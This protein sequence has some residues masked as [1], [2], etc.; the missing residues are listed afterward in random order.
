MRGKYLRFGAICVLLTSALGAYVAVGLHLFTSYS[1][2]YAGYEGTCNSLIHW[3]PPRVV[4][5]AFYA[6]GP[7]LGTLSYRSAVPATLAISLAIP[8]LTLTQTVEVHATPAAQTLTFKPPLAGTQ[9][10][11]ALVSPRQRAG[12]LTLQVTRGGSVVCNTSASVVL[13][14]RQWMH[15]ADPVAGDN[16]GYLAG[17]VTPQDP[18]ITALVG[19][20]TTRLEANPD[21]YPALDLLAG[22][23]AGR[24]TPEMVREEVDLLFDTLQFDYHLHY[25]QDNIPVLQNAD[26]IVQL[27]R[28]I[29]SSDDPTGM[30]VETTAILASAVERLGM[31]PFFVLVPGH[32][33]LGVA[34]GPSS[35]ATLAY[36]ETSDL[37][38][39]VTGNQANI[40]GNTEYAT[41]LTHGTIEHIVDIAAER[42][43]GI[44][45]IE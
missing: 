24:A 30:C 7:A 3:N 38:G 25:A 41:N 39:G 35:S 2:A 26:Q 27:P 5:T 17:W 33:F 14:S 44:Q 18:T 12:E 13:K 36:W 29:L 37:N 45:P 19:R 23:D 6:N 34:L 28:D 9:A 20:A 15:W 10:L 4:Y 31:R 22:Y 43:Q 32:V 16:S 21:A 42:A 8:G 1:L 40:Q 11:D